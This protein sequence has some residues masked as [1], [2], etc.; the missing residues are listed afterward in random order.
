M[1]PAGTFSDIQ[2][3]NSRVN[4]R[5]LLLSYYSE[6]NSSI[7]KELT[8]LRIPYIIKNSSDQT[9]ELFFILIWRCTQVAEGSALEMR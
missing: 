2:L 7:K 1:R 8:F 5:I 9:A 4:N 3:S 6:S